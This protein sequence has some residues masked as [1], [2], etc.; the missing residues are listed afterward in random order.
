MFCQGKCAR[1]V[2][3]NTHYTILLRNPRDVM[4]VGVLGKQIGMNGTLVEAYTDC[5][6]KPYGYLLID[7]SP[8]SDDAYRLKTNIFPDEDRIIYSPL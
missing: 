8:H 7:L 2:S 6:A 5:M 3:L 1:T 4:Q